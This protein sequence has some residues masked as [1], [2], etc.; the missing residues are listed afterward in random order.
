MLLGRAV[1]AT[2]DQMREAALDLALLG[3][4][5]VLVK[6]GHL[7]SEDSSPDVLCDGREVALLEA[8]R[9]ATRNTHG[10]GCT[11]SAA[12]AAL[13]PR[14]GTVPSAVPNAVRAAKSYV[15]AALRASHE[16]EVGSGRGPLHHFHALWPVGPEPSDSRRST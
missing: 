16:L 9:V 11:L 1:P 15:S 4:R 2:V 6:G 8:K 12:I 5:H 14:H 3:P 13:L 10:T 7:R